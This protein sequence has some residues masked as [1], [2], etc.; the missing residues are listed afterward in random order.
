M[1][2]FVSVLLTPLLVG[3]TL[4]SASAPVVEPVPTATASARPVTSSPFA[5]TIPTIPFTPTE[6]RN[7]AS[8]AQYGIAPELNNSAWFNSDVPLRLA[9]VRGQVV[10][11]EFWTFDCINCIRTLPYV[12]RWHETY[13]SQGLVVIGDH[14]PEFDYERD[15]QN[16]RAAA[17]RLGI[18]Y[19]IA[20]DNDGATWR[21]YN[22][23]YWPTMYLIDKW[24]TIRYFHIGEGAYEQTEAAIQALLAERYTPEPAA[25]T[26]VPRRYLSPTT[27][28]N[29]RTGAGIEYA[30][31]GAISPDMVFVVLGEESGW[32]RINYNDS[33]GYVS[34][35][36]VSVS[37]P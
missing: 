14:F 15:I 34:G 24:G 23:R 19:A 22:Q 3:C 16:V 35:E 10:L 18:T 5:T 25:S 8:L 7:M 36:Y 29:V 28:L 11:L 17:A 26:P 32:Y 13:A 12:Q 37:S 2:F 31:M 9:D 27:T 33:R 6:D 21:A 1:K 30:Q 4:A 20:Q